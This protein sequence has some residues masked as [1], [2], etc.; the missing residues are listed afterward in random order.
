MQIKSGHW[1]VASF[2][3]ALLQWGYPCNKV[4]LSLG[5]SSMFPLRW[6]WLSH[7]P[8]AWPQKQRPKVLPPACISWKHVVSKCWGT[9]RLLLVPL[10]IPWPR[11]PVLCLPQRIITICALLTRSCGQG[12]AKS[13]HSVRDYR[14]SYTEELLCRTQEALLV[15]KNPEL[16]C[17]FLSGESL[18]EWWL[19]NTGNWTLW[20]RRPLSGLCLCECHLLTAQLLTIYIWYRQ[21]HLSFL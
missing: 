3:I 15:L 5:N 7:A 4:L 8:W 18:G 20:L 2:P 10:T 16:C 17:I 13:L 9:D 12:C 6:Q 21:Q 19:V 1:D 14:K 11:M